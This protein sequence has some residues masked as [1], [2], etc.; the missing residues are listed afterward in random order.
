V[1]EEA[2]YHPGFDLPPL[3]LDL[4]NIVLENELVPEPTAEEVATYLFLKQSLGK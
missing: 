2:T 3:D 1:E 4:F